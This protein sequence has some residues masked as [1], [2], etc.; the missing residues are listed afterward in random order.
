MTEPI[1]TVIIRTQQIFE[2]ASGINPVKIEIEDDRVLN[3]LKKY[4][5]AEYKL[6]L[7]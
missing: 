7:L 2:T 3:I 6:T 4:K 5:S 1:E